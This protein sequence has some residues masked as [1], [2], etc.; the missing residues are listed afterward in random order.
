MPALFPNDVLSGV[1]VL[2]G[3]VGEALRGVDMEP[4]TGLGA[5]SRDTEVTRCLGG[6]FGLD[7]PDIFLGV[8]GDLT[9]ASVFRLSL[10]GFAFG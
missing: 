9:V 7:C 4:I 6:S 3:T 1:E 10:V 5:V 8:T 2:L